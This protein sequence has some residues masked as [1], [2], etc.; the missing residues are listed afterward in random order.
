MTYLLKLIIN[1]N[2]IFQSSY[3]TIAINTAIVKLLFIE[4][5]PST[6]LEN[7]SKSNYELEN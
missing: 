2:Y 7:I 5:Q 1:L 4:S 6:I 3:Y